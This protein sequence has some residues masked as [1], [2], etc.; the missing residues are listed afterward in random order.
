MV[1]VPTQD[2]HYS[3]MFYAQVDAEEGDV[4]EGDSDEGGA[5]LDDDELFP[6]GALRVMP[7]SDEEEPQTMVIHPPES[8]SGDPD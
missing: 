6:V 5:D 3:T 8:P 7:D 4:A 2:G 1:S